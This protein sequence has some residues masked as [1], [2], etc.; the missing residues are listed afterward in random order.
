MRNNHNERKMLYE[1]RAKN[2]LI[3]FYPDEFGHLEKSEKPDWTDKSKSIGVEV[4]RATNKEALSGRRNFLKISGKRKDEVSSKELEAVTKYNGLLYIDP[5]TNV[6]SAHIAAFDRAETM[7]KDAF[8]KKVR[9][10]NNTN[11]KY[12]ELNKLFLYVICDSPLGQSSAKRLLESLAAI[13]DSALKKF[14]G[15]FV[16]D[17]YFLYRYTFSNKIFLASDTSD[18][19]VGKEIF[20]RSLQES[21]AER[22]P[23]A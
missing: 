10:I 12:L 22:T 8:S 6:I 13:Q 2:T 23:D 19:E 7:L 14:D 4:V 3:H 18:V 9:L 16:D 20:V 21:K 5:N 15:V 11:E 17:G 1:C